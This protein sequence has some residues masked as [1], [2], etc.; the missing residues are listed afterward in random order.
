MCVCRECVN[1]FLKG[2]NV[3]VYV[4]G[5]VFACVLGK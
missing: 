4:S 1:R 3:D 2:V 5:G